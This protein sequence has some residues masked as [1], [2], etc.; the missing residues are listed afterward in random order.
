M[1]I[2]KHGTVS[3]VVLEGN[4]GNSCIN[5]FVKILNC[6]KNNTKKVEGQ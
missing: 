4:Q 5:V 2:K 3:L 6:V 1:K